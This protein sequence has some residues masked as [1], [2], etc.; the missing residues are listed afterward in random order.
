MISSI[1]CKRE[2]AQ[3]STAVKELLSFIGS[4]GGDSNRTGIALFMSDGYPAGNQHANDNDLQ[5]ITSF[6]YTMHCIGVGPDA[7]PDQL[8]HMAELAR[9]RYFSAPT[10]RDVK[11]KFSNLFN[12]GKTVWYSAPTIELPMESPAWHQ[13]STVRIWTTVNR[14]TGA[15]LLSNFTQGMKSQISFKICVEDVALDLTNLQL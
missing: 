15:P 4:K 12:F 11:E 8:E 10:A 2:E 13:G 14:Y 9:G 7:N 5:A 6:G 1:K 3:I